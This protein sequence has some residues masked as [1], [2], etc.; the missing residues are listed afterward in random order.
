YTN[1]ALALDSLE[2]S[3]PIE[4]VVKKSSEVNEIFDE[5]SYCKGAACIMMIT[6]YIDT[7]KKNTKTQ[8]LA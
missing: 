1:R 3:H 7:R 2:T 4:V 8:L 5:I 6:S